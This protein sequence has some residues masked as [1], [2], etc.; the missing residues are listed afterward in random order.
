M[1][2]I[3]IDADRFGDSFL[4]AAYMGSLL[5]DT[6]VYRPGIYRQIHDPRATLIF[7]GADKEVAQSPVVAFRALADYVW[8]CA[9]DG[10]TPEQIQQTFTSWHARENSDVTEALTTFPYLDALI[11]LPDEENP[12]GEPYLADTASVFIE[13]LS[14]AESIIP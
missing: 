14:I 7:D 4:I 5:T 8:S 9:M 10:Q 13:A 11:F 2:D 1:H 3:P 12:E 6:G